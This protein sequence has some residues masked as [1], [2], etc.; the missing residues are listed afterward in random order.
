MQVVNC[1]NCN[2]QVQI[3]ASREFGFC[4]F[5]GTKI[6]FSD[7]S[8]ANATQAFIGNREAALD[9]IKR[10]DEH[11]SSIAGDFSDLDSVNDDIDFFLNKRYSWNT[12][13]L[14]ISVFSFL[15]GLIAIY[16]I[17]D[18]SDISD[19]GW[20]IAFTV[21]TVVAFILLIF[22]RRRRINNNNKTLYDLSIEKKEISKRIVETY[23]AYPH[24]PIGIEYCR[25]EV[26]SAIYQ[27][28]RKGRAETIKEAVNL[29]ANDEYNFQMKQIALNTQAIAAENLRVNTINAVSNILR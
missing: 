25:P 6:M 5:C 8:P 20:A 7:D 16:S 2:G 4:S 3:D 13:G 29:L 21:I 14:V 27:Y 15:I 28:I 11:F 9:E 26:I 12:V 18:N 23:K 1:P 22:D 10:I 24:C 17:A 19:A